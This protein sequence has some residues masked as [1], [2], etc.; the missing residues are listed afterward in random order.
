MRSLATAYPILVQETNP[1]KKESGRASTCL[2]A[3]PKRRALG[4]SGVP[5]VGLS[6]EQK[7]SFERQLAVETTTKASFKASL[8]QLCG[9]KKKATAGTPPAAG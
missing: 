6:D 2:C 5:R 8:K 3:G 4:T 7:A 9:G 1:W